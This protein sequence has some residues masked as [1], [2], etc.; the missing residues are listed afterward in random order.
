MA[1]SRGHHRPTC[2]TPFEWRFA[3]WS[4]MARFFNDYWEGEAGDNGYVLQVVSV[5]KISS[6]SWEGSAKFR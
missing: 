2:E 6:R 5:E 1:Q 3:S 4:M